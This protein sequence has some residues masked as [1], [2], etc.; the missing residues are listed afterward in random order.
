MSDAPTRRRIRAQGS[1]HDPLVMRFILDASIQSGG[2]RRFDAPAADVPLAQAL[3]AV[4]GVTG[5]QVT[6]ETVLVTRAPEQ[7]WDG[8]KAPVAAAIREVLNRADPP[9]GPPPEAAAGYCDDAAVLAAVTEVLEARANPAIARHGGRVSAEAVENGIVS[10]RLSGGCQGC[11]AS[12]RTLRE[13]V[14]KMLR[15]A[16]PGIRGIVDVTDHEGGA[17]PYYRGKPGEGPAFFRPVPHDAFSIED[18][19]IAIDPDYLAPR[20]GLTAEALDAGFR[21]GDVV[22]ERLSGGAEGHLRIAVRGPARA[23]AAEILPD[24]TAHEIPSPREPPAADT[25]NAALA[26]RIRAHLQAL[27]ESGLPVT[28]GRLARALGLYL[29]GSIRQV[30][31]ALET[32]MH[33]DARAGRPFIAARAV[34]RGSGLPGRGFFDLARR[35]GRAPRATETDDAFHRRMLWASLRPRDGGANASEPQQ[36]SV[37]ASTRSEQQEARRAR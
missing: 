13:G 11:A 18:G 20:L 6:G 19:R 36:R 29:P 22:T 27:P 25:A 23:W 10:L 33:E 28:Y 17:N 16:V 12:S 9:L 4:D 34:G 8:L 35:L 2:T 1:A 21:N 26:A 31:A 30:T 14:E 5:V 37:D 3:F 32:T 7:D 15:A 24:G